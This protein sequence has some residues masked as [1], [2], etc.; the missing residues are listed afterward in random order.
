MSD[1]QISKTRKKLLSYTNW[2]V[3]PGDELMK[4]PGLTKLQICQ[5]TPA[6]ALMKWPHGQYVPV[7]YI[8]RCLNFISNFDRWCQVQREH[9]EQTLSKGWKIVHQARVVADFYIVI[10]WTKI[11]RSCY[12]SRQMYDNPAVSKFAVI[13]AAR[14]IATKSFAD[15]LW[16]A[17]DKLS[18]ELDEVREKIEAENIPMEKV[19][20]W[21]QKTE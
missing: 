14:S 16:V 2:M 18:K 17:S 4:L 20:E 11:E 15:T 3:L 21:F 19:V 1:T 5:I 6:K 12:G 10:D 9:Y 13:E 7:G 8:E